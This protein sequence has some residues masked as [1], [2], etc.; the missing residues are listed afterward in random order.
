MSYIAKNNAFGNLASGITSGTTSVTLQAGHGD[1]FPV[2]SSPDYTFLTF[3]D[4]AGNREI[5][6]VTNRA[7]ASD[8]LTIVRAQEGTTA[9]AWTTS[10]VV[11]LRMVAS[12]VQDAMGHPTK[13]TDAHAASA[14]AATPTGNLAGTTVAAQLAELESEKEPVFVGALPFNRGGTSATTRAGAVAALG[15]EA[16]EITVTT[17]ANATTDIGAAAGTNILLTTTATTITGFAAAAAGVRRKVRVNTGGITLTHSGTFVLPTA[18]N[19]VASGG[20]CFEA[21]STGSGWR[22]TEYLRADG[23]ALA[24][25]LPDSGT[26]GNILTSNG[27]GWESAAPPVPIPA[28]CVAHFAMSAAPSGWVKANGATVSRTTYAALFSAIGVV[29]GAGDGSTTFKLPDLRGEFLRG[30]DDGRG[31]DSG[32]GFGTWQADEFKSHTHTVGEI[33]SGWHIDSSTDDEFDADLNS[34][35]GATGG[36]E[37]RP[38]NVALLACIKY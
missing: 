24:D 26:A 35:T 14:I 11:E 7:A 33:T 22:I 18:A 2:I 12:L 30:W 9:R 8:V 13:T 36:S 15:L 3:E 1:R 4:A 31:V 19:I 27:T 34:E 23:K 28:G 21:Y 6:K 16:A 38:R 5:V 32:R 20:D 25:D 37:T 10:D 29:F 17:A